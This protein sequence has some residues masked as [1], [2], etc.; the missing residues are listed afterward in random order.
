MRGFEELYH[1]QG[2]PVYR[3][4]LALTGDE[5]QAEELLQETFYQAFLHIDRFEGR[6]SLYTWLCCI[7]KNAWLRECRRRSRYADTPY[8]ELKLEATAPTPEETMLR[9][10]QAQR[11]RQA[12]L[13]LEDPQREV[14]ILHAYGGLKL[15]EIAALH[16]KSESWARVTYFRARKTIQEVLSDET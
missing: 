4:L 14:F 10:E 1:T 2:R 3:F 6:S 5:G 9:R 13:E 8:E 11:L 12:V 7:G 16:Q 15:K